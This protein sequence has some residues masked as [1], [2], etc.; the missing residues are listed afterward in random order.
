MWNTLSAS[1]DINSVPKISGVCGGVVSDL[2]SLATRLLRAL[3][4]VA[5]RPMHER[6]EARGT[7]RR[8]ARFEQGR[9]ELDLQRIQR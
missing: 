3:R 2:R 6:G 5:L 1:G 4:E 9:G 8:R 7:C